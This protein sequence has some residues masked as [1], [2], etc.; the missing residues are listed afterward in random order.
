MLPPLL[1]ALLDDLSG[2]GVQLDFCILHNVL[3]SLNL[4]T[5]HCFHQFGEQPKVARSHVG[6]IYVTFGQENMFKKYQ[7]YSKNF[8][9]TQRMAKPSVK[10]EYTKPMFTPPRPEVLRW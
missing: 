7:T 5:I 1:E 6:R 8:A 4:G 9:D 10:K 2:N 3:A